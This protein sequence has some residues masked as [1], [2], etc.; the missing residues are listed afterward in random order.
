MSKFRT[1]FI[2]DRNEKIE[3]AYYSS[4]ETIN[5]IQGWLDDELLRTK[6]ESDTLKTLQINLT[7]GWNHRVSAQLK[8]HL[9]GD[10]RVDG[11]TL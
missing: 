4:I 8:Q 6:I 5:R 1:D 9:S 11:P 7:S 3:K 10:D 2:Q